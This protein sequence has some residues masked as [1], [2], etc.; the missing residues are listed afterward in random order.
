MYIQQNQN[1]GLSPQ[2]YNVL[3]VKNWGGGDLW[4]L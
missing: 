2:G 3:R 4:K 1:P